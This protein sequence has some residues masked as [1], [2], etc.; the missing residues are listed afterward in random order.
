MAD[1]LTETE[2]RIRAMCEGFVDGLTSTTLACQSGVNALFCYRLDSL[3]FEA[4]SG[5]WFTALASTA[6]SRILSD[7][8]RADSP[9]GF[10]QLPN[11]LLSSE[12]WNQ[13]ASALNLLTRVQIM[14]PM[15]F[16]VRT[17][18][19]S[20]TA[21]VS[22]TWP[23]DHPG[24]VSPPFPTLEPG[25]C[26]ATPPDPSAAAPG[27]WTDADVV[28][29]DVSAAILCTE[30]CESEQWTIGANRTDSEWRWKLI[31]PDAIYALPADLSAL[32][33]TVDGDGNQIFTAQG[34][35]LG[36]KETSVS[37]TTAT[38][39]DNEEDASPCLGT[40]FGFWHD[41]AAGKWIRFD[42][43]PVVSTTECILLPSSGSIH[44]P[45]LVEGDFAFGRTVE[46]NCCTGEGN[47]IS[48]T[49]ILGDDTAFIE[50]PLV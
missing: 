5:K 31:D 4:F 15:Q 25:Y 8:T 13:L 36:I 6:T 23:P 3:C 38:R 7:L 50:I 41:A 28:A 30:A 39:V 33:V 34:R 21:Q 43:V 27:D 37:K 19:G 18:T 49:P 12:C 45:A 35:V 2:V 17:S 40:D 32:V 46:T 11:T 24:C 48:V 1:F 44:A 47:S 22:T 29:S 20:A 16:Q 10:G 9:Q 14:L 42:S 26:T